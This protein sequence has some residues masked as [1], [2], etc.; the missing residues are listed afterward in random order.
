MALGLV[1]AIG[2]AAGA[3]PASASE[4]TRPLSS[5]AAAKADRVKLSK[6]IAQDAPAAS[7]DGGG[8][9]KSKKGVATLVL[10]AGALGYTIYSRSEDRVH[11]P[12]PR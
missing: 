9:F 12:A 10:F 7:T 4:P 11:S 2:L 8:F 3:P 6:A 5:A 1:V